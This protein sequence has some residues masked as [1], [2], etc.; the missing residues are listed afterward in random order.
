MI[1]SFFSDALVQ[2]AVFVTLTF[3]VFDGVRFVLRWFWKKT[4][5]KDE[6]FE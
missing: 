4:G 5:G 2:F 1:D 3:L 6:D